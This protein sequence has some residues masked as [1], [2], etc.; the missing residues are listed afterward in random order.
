VSEFHAH[1]FDPPRDR[2]AP[3]EIR[4]LSLGGEEMRRSLSG[5]TL[6][7]AIKP[8]CD[9]CRDFIHSDLHELT[10]V[11][12]VVVSATR[13]GDEWESARQRVLVAPDFMNELDVL[14]PPSYAL[15]DPKASRVICEGVLFGPAQVAS[16]IALYLNT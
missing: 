11:E 4:G 5:P 14:S 8:D 13:G 12:V 15:I 3:R 6:I 16:E 1:S 2:P 7:V 9:G 10:N